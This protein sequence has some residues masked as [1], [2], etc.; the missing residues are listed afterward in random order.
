MVGLGKGRRRITALYIRT[1]TMVD[2]IC[3]YKEKS[4]QLATPALKVKRRI[5]SEAA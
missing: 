5:S 2:D 4:I 3:L 1:G